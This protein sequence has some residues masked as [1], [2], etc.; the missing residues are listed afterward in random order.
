MVLQ[1]RN[2]GSDSV[3]PAL[4]LTA[5]DALHGIGAG[6]FTKKPNGFVD[7]ITLLLRKMTKTGQ[8][9]AAAAIR[10]YSFKGRE[11]RLDHWLGGVQRA[12]E[13]L[14]PGQ[15][16]AARRGFEVLMHG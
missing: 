15:D 9:G 6:S 16:V 12:Q 13:V 14:A 2:L 3:H 4:A 1:A 8:T 5:A 7:E 10:A 11:F